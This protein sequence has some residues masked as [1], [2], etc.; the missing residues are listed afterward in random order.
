[1]DSQRAT[2]VRRNMPKENIKCGHNTKLIENENKIVSLID[3]N[4]FIL[5]GYVHV[6]PLVTVNNVDYSTGNIHFDG[7]VLVKGTI[8]DGFKVEATGT[9]EVFECVGYL[10]EAVACL[11][12]VCVD[13]RA[14]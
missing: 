11:C 14:V 5:G 12:G 6:E 1:M 3:G 4:A 10:G 7:S 13:G 8:A 9:V 2:T